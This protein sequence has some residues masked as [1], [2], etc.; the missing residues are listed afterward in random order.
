VAYA[1]DPQR[2]RIGV[3]L[4]WRPGDIGGWLAD[5]AAYDAAGAD[6][7][8]IDVAGHPDLDPLALAAAMAAVTYRSLLVAPALPAA[9]AGRIRERDRAVETVTQL[10][11]GRLRIA[12][13]FE[14]GERRWVDTVL[15]DGR[16]A[17]SATLAEAAE[18]GHYGIVIAADARLIDLLRNPGDP[19]SRRDL[20]LSVG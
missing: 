5:G 9:D 12:G 7:L 10:S 14:D 11:R 17:W 3:R 18:H 13:T 4:G 8:W 20:E 2:I 1:D 15:P 6:A 19:G 16:A